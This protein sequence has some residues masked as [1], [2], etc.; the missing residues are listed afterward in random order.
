MLK[1]FKR[2]LNFE[3]T[4]CNLTNLQPHTEGME[5]INI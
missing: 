2:A 1:F 3:I 5:H 4:E